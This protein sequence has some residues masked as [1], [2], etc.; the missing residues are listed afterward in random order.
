MGAGALARPVRGRWRPVSGP[1][2]VHVSRTL[3][4]G[5]RAWFVRPGAAELVLVT[6]RR[7]LRLVVAFGARGPAEGI[8]LRRTRVLVVPADATTR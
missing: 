7:G 8:R 6:G 4:P 5:D 3:R 1:V 2:A